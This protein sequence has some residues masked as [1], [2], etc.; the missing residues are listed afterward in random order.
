M[1]RGRRRGRR[2]ARRRGRGGAGRPGAAALHHRG[3]TPPPTSSTPRSRSCSATTPRRPAPRSTQG[4]FRFDFPHFEAVSPD[5]LAELEA[6]VNARIAEDAGVDVLVDQP[7]GGPQ[8][9]RDRALR[10]EVRRHGA[11]RAHR[12]L[13]AGAVRRH[14]CRSH[15]RGGALHDAVGGLDRGEP[16]PHRGDHRSGGVHVPVQGAAGRRR[17]R[18]PPEGP[19][20]RGAA[21]RRRAA[22]Q[23]APGREG[24]RARPHRRRA[25][26]RPGAA[27][28][29]RNA[30]RA[31]PSRPG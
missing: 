19:D 23:A 13:L 4:R 29:A 18:A 9:R 1:H 26:A 31:A 30:W 8:H 7:G 15:R 12:R 24:P 3:A 22:G 20:R 25:G 14:A 5:Q 10:R 21:A 17:G 6:K 2:A 28:T 11:G 16:A 27:S